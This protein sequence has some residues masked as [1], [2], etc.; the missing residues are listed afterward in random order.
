VKSNSIERRLQE[1]EELFNPSNN[2]P[3]DTGELT[4]DETVELSFNNT[5]KALTTLIITNPTTG[6]SFEAINEPDW[7]ELVRT[8]KRY[9]TESTVLRFTSVDIGAR[10]ESPVE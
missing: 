9:A 6:E 8:S 10:K 1:L 2:N 7:V 3:F 5:G 4:F